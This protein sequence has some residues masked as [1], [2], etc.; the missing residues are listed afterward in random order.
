MLVVVFSFLDFGFLKCLGGVN[1][2]FFL[3]LVGGILW[4]NFWS[5]FG[6]FCG[7]I[8]GILG[9]GCIV[10]K[11]VGCWLIVGWVVCIWICVL[12]LGCFSICWWELYKGE[13]EDDFVCIICVSGGVGGFCI[14]GICILG[15]LDIVV[16]GCVVVVFL[17]LGWLK[18]T[19]LGGYMIMLEFI[20]LWLG[21]L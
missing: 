20:C 1:F 16:W 7:N 4:G 13:V 6:I 2:E 17:L 9:I 21:I 18:W 14:S 8:C 5:G 12:M 19:W 15:V 10:L 11:I 3:V